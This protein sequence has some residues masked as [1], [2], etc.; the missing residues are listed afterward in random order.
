VV[1]AQHPRLEEYDPFGK[2]KNLL[3]AAVESIVKAFNGS[4]IEEQT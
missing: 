3:E 4:I 2:R 1:V